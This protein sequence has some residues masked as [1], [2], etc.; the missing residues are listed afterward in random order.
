MM[1]VSFVGS[2]M[3][4]TLFG[5]EIID[6]KPFLKWAGGK[7]QLINQIE[8]R[9]P[10]DIK[11][12]KI[13]EKYFEPFIG[14]GA[15]FF[16]L[17]SNY[18]IKKSYIYD[19]NPELIVVYKTIKN[20]PKEL[21]NSLSELKDNFIPLSH[22]ERKKIYLGIRKEFNESIT[23]F[24]YSKYSKEDYV[25]RSTYFIL[26]NKTCFNGLFRVNKKGEFNVPF[27]RYKNPAIFDKDNILACSKALKNTFIEE[28]SFLNSEK[29]IDSNSF[30][31]LDPPYRPIT[32]SASFTSY[33][34][35]DFNDDDQI[36]L[37]NFYKR[38]SDN[39]AKLLLSNSDPKNTDESDDFFDDLYSDFTIDRVF[40]KRSINRN[41]KKRGAVS[42]ILVKNY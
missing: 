31:Y 37:A 4:E 9:L 28:G 34:K 21:I 20:N 10:Q 2:I 30:V 33:S 24:D 22:E 3:Q 6:A 1:K 19:I 26:M 39:G 7:T 5:E 36:E 16:Y 25:T 42:E 17:S 23:E 11:S 38:M 40:A 8:E 13:I 35:F 41:G 15:L 29:L 12:N 32:S 14:G 18:N 27:G